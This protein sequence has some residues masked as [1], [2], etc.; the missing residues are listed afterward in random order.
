M[1]TALQRKEEW[2]GGKDRPVVLVI[3][4]EVGDCETIHHERFVRFVEGS[5]FRY[6]FTTGEVCGEYS[7]DAAVEWAVRSALAGRSIV[8]LDVEFGDARRMGLDILRTL[9]QRLPQVPVIMMTK[10]ESA[11]LAGECASAGA[12]NYLVKWRG[13][14]ESLET[15]LELALDVPAD[16]PEIVGESKW[17]TSVRRQV[18]CF[19]RT[20]GDPAILL[21][22]ES[23]TGKTTVANALHRLSTGRP[24]K[25]IVL[26]CGTMSEGL[27]ESMLFGHRAGAFTGATEGR[28]GVVSQAD[29]GM[30]FLD[31]IDNMPPR[32]Q[33]A[34]LR[35]LEAGVYRTVGEDR[36]RNVNVRIAAA[37]NKKIEEL[38][39]AGR[40]REDLFYRLCVCS[41]TLLPLRERREDIR[42]IIDRVMSDVREKY[43]WI[44][45]VDEDALKVMEAYDWPGNI[46]EVKN[47][48]EQACAMKRGGWIGRGDLRLGKIGGRMEKE[49]SGVE[50]AGGGGWRVP[51]LDRGFDLEL[52]MARM[53]AV[54]IEEAL[55]RNGGNL[56][57]AER[58]LSGGRQRGNLV[59]NRLKSIGK[60]PDVLEG[61]ECCKEIASRIDKSRE[62]SE[63]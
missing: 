38:V 57:G 48:L 16:V 62:V 24:G 26:D 58:L 14:R 63:E 1:V 46:R 13:G 39:A 35:L 60:F 37:C 29:G 28:P 2:L 12:Y 25:F 4:D 41:V 45:G 30:L 17:A 23:G 27:Q 49:G 59:R 8:L 52:Y 15:L 43:G 34:L 7:V 42:S 6:L 3:D 20:P 61:L 9:K 32:L 51:V 31:N 21:L 19:A 36:E 10:L 40:F 18:F 50:S 22:G 55:R 5:R 11:E 53:E 56:K 54:V 44:L 47:V 33:E